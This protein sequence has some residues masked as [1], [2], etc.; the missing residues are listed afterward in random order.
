MVL[1]RLA[2]CAYLLALALAAV[3]LPGDGAD[4]VDATVVSIDIAPSD[5]PDELLADDDSFDG[6]DNDFGVEGDDDAVPVARVTLPSPGRL[7]QPV[8][9]A[10]GAPRPSSAIDNL[11]RPPRTVSSV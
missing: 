4:P 11:F 1:A 6:D 2:L 5:A 7:A 10:L 9:A 3:A 8:A